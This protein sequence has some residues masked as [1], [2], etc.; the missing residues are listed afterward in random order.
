MTLR[1]FFT[2]YVSMVSAPIN[3][4]LAPV[5]LGIGQ[6]LLLIL[7]TLLNPGM[8]EVL[9]HDPFRAII[10]ILS[11]MVV[12]F[13]T[14]TLLGETLSQKKEKE[15]AKRLSELLAIEKSKMET[16]ISN[17]GDTIIA[18]DT[19]GTIILA[20]NTIES[21]S[22]LRRDLIIGKHIQSIFP[23]IDLQLE[24]GNQEMDVKN[25]ENKKVHCQIRV[26]SL[27][28]K[29]SENAGKLVIIH[30]ISKE[31]ELEEMKIDFVSMAA[32]EL[33]TPLTS[34]KGYVSVLQKDIKAQLDAE[35]TTF[36]ER[37]DIAS[38]QLS[39]LVENLLNVSRIERGALSLHA[40]P[41][42]WASFLKDHIEMLSDRAREKNISVTLRE[43]ADQAI[44]V[45]ADKFRIGEV[46]TNLLANAINYTPPDGAV[47]I[48]MEKSDAEIITHITDTGEGIP[49]EALPHLFTKFFRVSGILEKGS[50]GTGLG[51]FI[52]KSI[53]E[54]HQGRIWAESEVGKGSTFSFTLPVT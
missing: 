17:I 5:L 25:K 27:V 21:I 54:M 53:V 19:E 34:I 1:F 23:E 38:E 33:R 48:S 7:A 3:Q 6:I 41:I 4:V 29:K 24:N 40:E 30:D 14:A 32:H 2:L 10:F 44:S 50:K 51:L 45:M 52:S 46:V 37:I 20:N 12:M 9:I 39:V 36:L 16:V 11:P 43:P 31:K 26:K 49:R 8:H 42:H 22:T 47:T 35:H 15:E 13:F 18:C 28:D